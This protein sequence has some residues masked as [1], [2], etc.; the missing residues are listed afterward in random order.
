MDGDAA[1]TF[2]GMV[3]AMVV[4]G[5]IVHHAS[6]SAWQDDMIAR[7]LAIYCPENG[8]FAFKG[9]CKE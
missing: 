8:H 3:V 6:R 5:G 1:A 7:D 4:A 2:A 9:E